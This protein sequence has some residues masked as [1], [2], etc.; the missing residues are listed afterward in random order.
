MLAVIASLLATLQMLLTAVGPHAVL[1]R[2]TPADVPYG[3]AAGDTTC[4]RWEWN[5]GWDCPDNVWRVRISPELDF[6]S[7]LDGPGVTEQ[8]LRRRALALSTMAHE[9]AHVYDGMDDGQFN[10]SPGHPRPDSYIDAL[11]LT[12]GRRAWEPSAW[13]CW[14]GQPDERV[15]PPEGGSDRAR[16]EWYACEVARTGRLR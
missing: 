5:G 10:G 13:Y 2:A 15:S 12:N 1:E 6:W 3:V 7:P 4:H 9:L 11:T 14:A 8:G 16:A